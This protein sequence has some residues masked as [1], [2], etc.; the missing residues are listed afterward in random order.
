M[1]YIIY[2][3]YNL[4]IYNFSLYIF[5]L[6]KCFKPTDRYKYPQYARYFARD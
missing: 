5:K 6:E 4:Y 1:S 3:L 2:K